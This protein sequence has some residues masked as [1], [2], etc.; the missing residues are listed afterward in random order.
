MLKDSK[1]IVETRGIS[2]YFSTKLHATKFENRVKENRELI[3]NKL[4]KRYRVHLENDLFCDIYLYQTIE[5]RGFYIKSFN[6][7]Y[8]N[9][10]DF[11]LTSYGIIR[12]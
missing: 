12:Q 5:N 6:E 8:T 9:I 11:V 3:K 1:F 7:V 2:Y 4:Y 10:D